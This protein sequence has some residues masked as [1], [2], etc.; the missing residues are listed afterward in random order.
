MTPESMTDADYFA[1]LRERQR[2]LIAVYTESCQRIIEGNIQR[3]IAE[4]IKRR[5]A[6]IAY[7]LGEREQRSEF[8]RWRK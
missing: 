3:Q 2:Q 7:M 6:M 1:S 4:G 8:I 5:D